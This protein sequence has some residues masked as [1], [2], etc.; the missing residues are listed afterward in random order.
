M[1]LYTSK[2]WSTREWDCLGRSENEYAKDNAEGKLTTDHANTA[3]LFRVLDL[4][5]DWNPKWVVNSTNAGYKSGYRTLEV[6]AKVGG[7]KNS[8]HTKGCAADIHISGQDDNA[9]ALAETIRAATAAWGLE[10][11][12]NIGHYGD[13][14]HIEFIDRRTGDW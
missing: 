7:A 14:I 6:N 1:P 13:W 9:F 3:N 2:N 12:L 8:N 10:N 4:V 5:R 11:N